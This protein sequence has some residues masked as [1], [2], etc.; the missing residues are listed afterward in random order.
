M[1]F[2]QH[3][4]KFRI[5][6][7]ELNYSN[8]IFMQIKSTSHDLK[9]AKLSHGRFQELP[10]VEMKNCNSYYM[11]NVF[12]VLVFLFPSPLRFVVGTSI[13]GSCSLGEELVIYSLLSVYF[14]MSFPNSALKLLTF[15]FITQIWM[16]FRCVVW[17]PITLWID[18]YYSA[19]NSL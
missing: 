19:F 13:S 5:W 1:G 15:V 2:V 3:P 12:Y 6:G 18:N 7:V 4:C 11:T 8:C 10:S 16:L 17:K 9:T 14:C